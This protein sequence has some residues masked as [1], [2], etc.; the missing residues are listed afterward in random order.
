MS[1]R[2]LPAWLLLLAA[3]Q[4]PAPPTADLSVS[5]LLSGE[6]EPGFARATQVRPLSFPRDHGAH[7]AFRNEWWYL[8]GNLSAADGHRYGFQATFFRIALSPR[9]PPGAS[10]WRSNQL[11]MAH[12]ALSDLSRGA[13]LA[14]QRFARQGNRLAGAAAEP[15][16]V[17]LEDWRLAA[18]DR[19][20][21]WHLQLPARGFSLELDLQAASPVVLQGDRGL[22]RKGRQAGNASY[23]YSIPRLRVTGRLARG[24]QEQAVRG[25]AWFDREWGSSALEPGQT[26]WD[27][28]SLQLDDGRNLM[29]YRLRRDTGEPDPL[30]AGSLSDASGLRRRLAPGQVSSPPSPTGAAIPSNGACNWPARPTPGGCEPCSRTRRC[31]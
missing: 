23:Y 19:E 21:V 4:Q 15:F 10:T 12:A 29:Y 5:D 18:T 25:L 9:P 1:R 24:G 16:E 14:D 28:F 2:W 8:T 31:A 26:G 13:H 7:P 6:S 27:W 30:S 17:W 20:G 11:W 22:S 3:C